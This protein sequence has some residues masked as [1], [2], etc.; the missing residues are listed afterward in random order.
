GIPGDV[1]TERQMFVEPEVAR[2]L[3]F[4]EREGPFER[5]ARALDLVLRVRRFQ[6]HPVHARFL[7][8][9]LEPPDAVFQAAVRSIARVAL[10]HDHEVRVELVLHVDCRTVARDCL[11]D[12]NDFHAR[13]L[14]AALA[15]DRLIV[16]ANAGDARTDALANHAA[17][18]HDAAVAGVA[19]ENDREL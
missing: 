7:A 12:G 18:R 1:D 14:R 13:A 9:S 11:L 4:H 10:R 3:P 16:D 8:I 6:L 2:E 15:L 5:R 17:H 19:V